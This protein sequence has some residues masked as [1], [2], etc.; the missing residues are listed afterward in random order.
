MI[1]F[2]TPVLELRQM[3]KKKL[4]SPR[5]LY[6]F[7]YDRSLKFNSRFNAYITI[8]E[9]GHQDWKLLDSLDPETSLFWG[10]PVSFKDMF[11]TQGI[12]TTAA[13]RMLKGYIPPYDATVVNRMKQHGALILGKVNQDEFA[14][15]SSGRTSY[16]GPSKNPWD[17]NCVPGGSSSGSAV[18]VAAYLSPLSVGTDT[19]GSV[20]QPAAFC[21][22]VGL[23]PTYG[24]I[25]RYGMIAFASSL[26]QAGPVA[27]TV[28]DAALFLQ[29]VAG[30]DSHDLTTSCEPVMDWINQLDNPLPKGLRIGFPKEFW[31][32]P[33]LAS[34]LQKIR[35]QLEL[36]LS[37]LGC[38]TKW[39]SLPLTLEYG[40]AVYYLIS[41]SE[42]SSN[43]SR[44]DGVRYGHRSIEK[45][46]DIREFYQKNRS[47]GFGSEVKTRILLGTFSLSA[48]YF[49]AYFKKAAQVRRLIQ[50]EFLDTLNE[51]DLLLIPT[52][53]R[54]AFDLN[55]VAQDPIEE[56]YN[57]VFT[58]AANLTGLPAISIPVTLS[59]KRRPLAIQLIARPFR[60]D[61]LF[62]VTHRLEKM[63]D[64]R[65]RYIHE[66][67]RKI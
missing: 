58:V 17:E 32:Y 46:K 3:L 59:E 29:A 67:E 28:A 50:N 10:I 20:R 21:G 60:E 26:D 15:G 56:Y 23:K 25:S 12:Q 6:E 18:A 2:W 66:L 42:A 35:S 37:D 19:G 54:D 31:E 49:D 24:R 34:E 8:V 4:I 7:F 33:G 9:P 39:V 16:F 38:E 52:T 43:L 30:A 65:K 11:V 61:H 13:S 41:S 1:Q 5:E 22:L 44:Y 53:T 45:V 40:I 47:E 63:I 55:F 14:M 51:V 57:D 48:G 27:L 64:F 62:Q 36:M